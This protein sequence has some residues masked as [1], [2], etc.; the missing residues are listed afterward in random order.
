MPKRKPKTET[1]PPEGG[2][3]HRLKFNGKDGYPFIIGIP[4]RDLEHQ[5]LLELSM[6]RYLPLDDFITLLCAATPGRQLKGGTPLY[7]PAKPHICPECKQ[8]FDVWGDLHNHA[9][10]HVNQESDDGTNIIDAD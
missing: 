1:P 10:T 3:I 4:A 2:E 8:E 5:E 7:S 6:A 9:L